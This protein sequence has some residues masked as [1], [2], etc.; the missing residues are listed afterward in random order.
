M[1][2]SAGLSFLIILAV[3]VTTFATRVVP[4]LI[5][6]KGKEIPPIIQYLGKV[7]TPA[8]IGMLVVY[9]L[10]S[11]SVLQ[12]PHGIPEAIAV[13]VTAVLHVWKRNNLLSIG[14]GTILYMILIQMVF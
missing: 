6:P 12:A 10:K 5:F 14:G 3:A 2:V 13:T 9:C 7:L 11:T 8:V 1:P 4:F